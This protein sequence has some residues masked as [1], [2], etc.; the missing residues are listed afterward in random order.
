MS[1]PSVRRRTAIGAGWMVAWR[2]VSRL[3]G[4]ASTLIMARILVPADFGLLAMATGFAAAV[5]ALSQFGLQDALV[6]HPDAARLHDTAFTLQLIRGV[7]T[8]AIVALAAPLAARW[9]AEPRLA[10]VLLVLA[11]GALVAGAENIGIVDF[12]RELRFD[13]Q[14][15]L[16]LGPRLL[17]LAVALPLAL[18]TRSY[19]ALLAGI[20]VAR[21]ARTVLT[22]AHPYRPRLSLA[23]WRELASFSA[24]SWAGSLAGLVWDRC[25]P[26]VLGPRLGAT[27]LGLYVQA[28]DLAAL[29]ATELILPVAEALFAGFAMAQ[30]QNAAPDTRGSSADS[31][32]LVAV[33]LLMLILPM[34]VT[35][36]CA[37]GDV[38]WVLL[39]PRWADARGLLAIL[40]WQGVFAPFGYVIGV[41]LLANGLVRRNFLANVAASALRLGA[42]IAAVALTARLDIM[43]WVVVGV[44][45]GEAAIFLLALPRRAVAGHRVAGAF[46]R[47]LLA[48]AASVLV[49]WALGLAWTSDAR[50]GIAAFAHGLAI[51]FVTVAVY[52]STLLAAWAAAGRPGGPERLV[53]DLVLPRLGRVLRLPARRFHPTGAP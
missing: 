9:F 19:W 14:F 17:Q 11:A 15:G 39:G 45:A 35:L 25:D 51:G 12:R 13:R 44:V 30:R 38:V 37:A 18:A 27:G 28:A 53:L 26:F 6:R 40:A 43:A 24:W 46:A 10:A 3:L 1:G 22:Y 32:P 41:T 16:L 8:A 29:P 50:H 4:L 47:A 20:F 31:A 34:V 23:G 36:S 49:L 7:A 5:E 52:G 21:L 33:S 2:M 42:L 48:M